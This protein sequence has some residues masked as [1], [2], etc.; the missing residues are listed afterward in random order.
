ML[1][2]VFGVIAACLTVGSLAGVPVVSVGAPR[3][4]KIAVCALLV[5]MG[6]LLPGATSGPLAPAVAEDVSYPPAPDFELV[7]QYGQTHTLADCQ[8]KV[9]FLNFWTTWCP[10]CI[11]EMPD[12]E[13]LY[14][15][16]GENAGDVLIL[17]VASP[18]KSDDRDVAGITAFLEENGWTYPVLMDETNQLLSAFGIDAFP[19][20]FF[21]RTDGTVFGYVPGALS[22]EDMQ[23]LIQMTLDSS[24]GE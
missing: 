17:G 6:A 12:I 16:L 3:R 11:K 20:S 23:S 9:V 14:H 1:Y 2:F 5:A 13:E 15:E 24:A 18:L 19:M 22:K 8:G 21:I 4:A 10:W 7:D